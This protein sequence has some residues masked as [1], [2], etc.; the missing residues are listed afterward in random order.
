[1]DVRYAAGF[2][3]GEGCIRID[4]LSI[5]K[6]DARPTG[7]YRYQLKT[8]VCQANPLPLIELQKLFGGK[9]HTDNAARNKSLKNRTRHG[10]IT[11]SRISY[12][13][14]VS[15]RPFL[16]VKA[17]EADLA[18]SFFEEMESNRTLFRVHRGR[19]PNKADIHLS[20]NQIIDR[21]A[22]IKRINYPAIDNGPMPV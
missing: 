7:Y 1:M 13:F 11:W 4:R 2:F 17:E 5:P 3:D 16:I 21:L 14:L 22:A 19:P 12:D 6:S 8:S 10:W 9:L 20:R 15:V 18:I